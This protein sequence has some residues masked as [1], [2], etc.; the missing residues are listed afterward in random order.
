MRKATVETAVIVA[1]VALIQGVGVAAI[2]GIMS[3]K[4][5]DDESYRRERDEAE[6]RR[7]RDR[8]ELD[9]AI[10][11]LMFSTA[12]GT[13]VLLHQAHGEQV[14]GNVNAALQS[15]KEAKSECN[16]LVNKTAVGA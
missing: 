7:E 9:A 8:R 3:R 13:E 6:R 5:R 10:L 1:I 4:A 16:R 12:G 2:N 14:N 11:G 15:I